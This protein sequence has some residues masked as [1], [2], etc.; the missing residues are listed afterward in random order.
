[1]P[2]P[3]SDDLRTKVLAAVDRGEKKSHLSRL[4]GISRNTIDLWLKRR[5]CTGSATATR[6]YRRGPDPKIVDLEAF[7]A[8]AQEHG[9]LTQQQMADRWPEPI[10]NRT[11]GAALRRIG[12]TRKKR[13]TATENVTR[14][15]GKRF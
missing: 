11:I 15:N 6:H 12:F 4:F 5:E 8:F 2:A 13:L 10:T 14:R 3:Y 1:M 7:R 9:H